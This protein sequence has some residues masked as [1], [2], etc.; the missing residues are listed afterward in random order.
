VP[1]QIRLLH[2][3]LGFVDVAQHPIGEA[4]QPRP[5]IDDA[6][7]LAD[8]VVRRFSIECSSGHTM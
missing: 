3:V 4:E 8:G 7:I 5:M 2:D 6:A 1:A